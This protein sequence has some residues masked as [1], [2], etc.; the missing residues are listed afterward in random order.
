M[1]KSIMAKTDGRVIAHAS[2]P[3]V[4][5]A[6]CGL[7]GVAALDATQQAPRPVILLSCPAGGASRALAAMLDGGGYSVIVAHNEDEALTA[8]ETTLVEA[9][10]VH[11]SAADPA[12]LDFVKLQRMSDP[13]DPLLP[14]VLL[15]DGMS[16]ELEQASAEA[17]VDLRLVAPIE[18]RHLLDYIADLRANRSRR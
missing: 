12:R 2:D 11:L 10:L 8:L 9:V 13:A 18:P 16:P 3:V 7:K 5:N 4:V 17:Q 14:V 15:S 1:A 6:R